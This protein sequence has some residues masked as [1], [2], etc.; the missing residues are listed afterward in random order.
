MTKNMKD[1]VHDG[2]VVAYSY[3]LYDDKTGKVLFEATADAPDVMLF[4]KSPEVLPALAK[5][6]EG[7]KEGDKFGITLPPEAAF[8]EYSNDWVKILPKEIFMRDG[9]LAKEVV[10]G[11]VLPMMTDQGFAMHGKVMSIGENEVVMDFNHPFAG[12]TVRYEGKIEGV[13]EATPDE[14]EPK[15]C[16][17]CHGGGC[18]GGEKDHDCCG[19]G[20]GCCH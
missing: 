6:M 4:G 8:G 1:T 7:L 9:E 13:R 15:G 10:E 12:K 11:A 20:G 14:L 18:H 2:M 16:G 3:K 5:V 19:G 17:G